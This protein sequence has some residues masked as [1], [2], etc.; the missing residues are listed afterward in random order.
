MTTDISAPRPDGDQRDG[1]GPTPFRAVM[2]HHAKG[3]AVI[4]AGDD[5]P[6][7]LCATSLATV[8]LEPPHVSFAVGLQTASWATMETAPYVAV[9]LLAEG[10]ED[11]A[12]RFARTGEP[13][14]GTATS[15]HRGAFGLPMLD[16]VLASLV[17]AT[18]GVLTVADH[19]LVVGRV[20]DARHGVSGGP[21]VHHDGE[22]VRLASPHQASTGQARG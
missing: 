17:V 2:R 22:F 10:Q 16:G 11:V 18:V 15:W 13:K 7:G 21:L 8:S 3:V 20:L 9:N 1:V 4:T 14:F 5:A 19:A 6:V 12:R